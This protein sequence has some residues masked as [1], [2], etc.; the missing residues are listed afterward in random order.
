MKPVLIHVEAEEELVESTR[1]YE[2][3]SQGLGL[4]FKE[5]VKRAIFDLQAFPTRFGFHRI[6]PFRRF[7]LGRFPFSVIYL[8]LPDVIWI[9]A[10]AHDKREPGY[11]RNRSY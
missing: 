4:D 3:R 8:E 6:K 2:E 7:Q 10:I 11:W 9:A 5:R 1:Y